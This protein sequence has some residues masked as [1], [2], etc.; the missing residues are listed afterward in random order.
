M[1]ALLDRETVDVYLQEC[2]TGEHGESAYF[3]ALE[4]TAERTEGK[5]PNVTKVTGDESAPLV[6]RVVRS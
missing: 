4:F 2:L 3:K 1:R 6:I 5:V